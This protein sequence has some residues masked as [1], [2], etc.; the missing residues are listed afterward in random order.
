MSADLT[1]WIAGVEPVLDAPVGQLGGL[2]T[3][4]LCSSSPTRTGRHSGGSTHQHPYTTGPSGPLSTMRKSSKSPVKRLVR[5]RE[6]PSLQVRSFERS[7]VSEPL[8]IETQ[9]PRMFAWPDPTMAPAACRPPTSMD[10]RRAGYAERTVTTNDGVRL[11][12]RD[13]GSP[14][15]AEH[16]VV[17]L[18]GLCLTQA[19]WAAQLPPLRRRWGNA[20]R[21]I[22]YDHRGHG[23]STGAPM[24]TYRDRRACRRP[25]RGSHRSAR[26]GPAHPCG[27]L[28]GRHDGAGLPRPLRRRPS[29]GTAG[30]RPDRD[31]GGQDRERGIGRL[32]ATP[33]TGTLFNLVN[34]MPRD[35]TDQAVQALLRPVSAVLAAFSGHGTA[36]TNGVAAVA[37]TAVRTTSLTTAAGFFL[38]LRRY[39]EYPHAFDHRRE[40]D[41]GQRRSGHSDSGRPRSR[42]NRRHPRCYPSA[43]TWRGARASPGGA[44]S[45]QHRNQPRDG[46]APPS[47]ATTRC[48]SLSYS[49][50]RMVPSELAISPAIADSWR[51]PRPG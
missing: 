50:N 28:D 29:G 19:S 44:T 38:G 13:Y 22:T 9:D 7:T 23:Q 31:R 39:D 1:Y 49:E 37:A 45:C 25:R 21:I 36:S 34:R 24:R 4:A 14:G 35:A 6:T 43:P 47:C 16:T 42:P 40:D 8:D 11:A 3:T 51:T 5:R 26:H 33:A 41:C 20:V 32:L 46:P 2:L 27:A 10:A 12:V 17:L 30:P 15:A 18:H 48:C